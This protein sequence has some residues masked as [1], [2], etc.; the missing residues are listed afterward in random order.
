MIH[1]S[2]A[3]EPTDFDSKV[4]R[5]GLRAISEMIGE[6]PQFPR[7][8]GKE[9]KVVASQKVEIPSSSFPTYWTE[10]LDDLMSAYGEI[11]AYSCFRIHRVTGGR[12]VDHM[13]PKSLSWDQ[14][15]EWSNYRL[16]CSWMN[17]SKREFGDVLDPFLVQDGWFE[18]ELVGF[19]VIPAN[20]LG[21]GIKRQ[22]EDTISRL[23]LNRFCLD[24]AEDAEDYWNGDT[25]FSV[26]LRESPFV[27]KE[28]R[29]QGRL[30]A[31]DI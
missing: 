26:L 6:A 23:G 28:L 10:V 21:A 1:V 12:S 13:A 4:R 31:G 9:F 16:A 14:V 17:S 15:Y 19:Q 20:G 2:P 22:V 29:R 27:T 18:L 11:C 30:R 8:S 25:S 5:P 7:T 3:Q 24:R